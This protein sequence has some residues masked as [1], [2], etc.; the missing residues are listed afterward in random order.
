[1]KRQIQK[2]YKSTIYN[3]I[4]SDNNWRNGLDMLINKHL[5]ELIKETKEY[6]YA[7]SQAK[8]KSKAQIWVALALLRHQINQI[9]IKEETKK[10]KKKLS[11]EELN[12]ILNT[13]EKL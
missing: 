2:F 5:S 7:I 10:A 6:D 11:K 8:D 12:K 13:L 3:I 9:G 4:M 1:M